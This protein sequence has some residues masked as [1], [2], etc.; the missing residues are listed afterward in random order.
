M[1]PQ[2][3]SNTTHPNKTNTL[4]SKDVASPRCVFMI[5]SHKCL[6]AEVTACTPLPCSLSV[7]LST[8]ARCLLPWCSWRP[9]WPSAS[10][11][12]TATACSLMLWFWLAV[13]AH[14]Q[15][16]MSWLDAPRW[17]V[18]CVC[19]CVCVYSGIAHVFNN[20]SSDIN[21]ADLPSNFLLFKNK[22]SLT[23]QRGINKSRLP[24]SSHSCDSAHQL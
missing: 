18:Q 12:T 13:P 4:R 2:M 22:K 15:Q 9:V 5:W 16:S 14:R 23:S 19:V 21:M 8:G 6:W 17:E 20:D 10:P 24:F 7:R 3:G 1:W 11:L